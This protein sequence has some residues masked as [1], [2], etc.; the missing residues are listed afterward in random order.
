MPCFWI[1]VEQK[2]K[3]IVLVIQQNV[4]FVKIIVSIILLHHWTIE[5]QGKLIPCEIGQEW[6][7]LI[8]RWNS[9]ITIGDIQNPHTAI[10]EKDPIPIS[11]IDDIEIS[12]LTIQHSIK[13]CIIVHIIEFTIR[14]DLCF[15]LV[16]H[17]LSIDYEKSGACCLRE[18]GDKQQG[19]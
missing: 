17:Y 18:R 16:I 19:H 8:I 7:R 1:T 9:D 4:N 14:N 12:V 13:F 3:S 15:L 11:D 10:T 2:T 5:G 6:F